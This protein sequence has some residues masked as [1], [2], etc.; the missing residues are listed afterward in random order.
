MSQD[1]IAKDA[2]VSQATVS[3]VIRGVQ[4]PSRR[5]AKKLAPALGVPWTLLMEGDPVKI[6]AALTR[7]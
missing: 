6:Q 5:I 3:R 7:N 2:G 1:S 4:Q